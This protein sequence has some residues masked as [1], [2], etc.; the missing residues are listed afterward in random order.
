MLANRTGR[1]K[2]AL[3]VTQK[4]CEEAIK[5]DVEGAEMYEEELQVAAEQAEAALDRAASWADD[6]EVERDRRKE[7]VQ[8]RP[9]LTFQ[10][11]NG[12]VGDWK[13]FV[14][15]A[16]QVLSMYPGDE[17]QA[18]NVLL[19]FC[20]VK[21]KNMITKY[22]G[23]EN[24]V[25]LALETLNIHFG[26]SHLSLP[27]IVGQIGKV[28]AALTLGQVP[29]VCTEVLSLLEVLSGLMPAE[30]GLDAS[31]VHSI[32]QKLLLS[33]TE[34]QDLVPILRGDKVTLKYMLEY[35]RGR[36]V[37]FEILKRTILEDA[38]PT[39]QAAIGQTED[40]DAPPNGQEEDDEDEDSET[41]YDGSASSVPLH[42][43]DEEV[44]EEDLESDHDDDER[45]ECQ[46]D[47][48]DGC[49]YE[50]HNQLPFK[51]GPCGFC[52]SQSNPDNGHFITECED[53]GP[54]SL[55]AVKRSGHCVWC[56]SP[57]N[58]RVHQLFGC[59][60]TTFNNKPLKIYCEE[61]SRNVKMCSDP[62]GHDAVV[63]PSASND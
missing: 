41:D 12:E 58:L 37:A 35:V 38:D 30:D 56:L 31:L 40:P 13:R 46:G 45:S 61:C 22:A 42:S 18:L 62:R 54:N 7:N 43:G 47:D 26:F 51:R 6:R 59:K 8:A 23:R 48:S 50:E 49:S 60:T 36:F 11:Y 25:Q 19:Q 16:R 4:N 9:H 39:T 33:P 14:G 21:I 52:V 15:D 53:I 27:T 44:S 34:L 24:A 10:V 55:E 20:S 2:L 1:V 3:K 5:D 29:P 17:P 28:T 57:L 63:V 32:F